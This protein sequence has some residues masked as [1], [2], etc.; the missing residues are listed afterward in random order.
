VGTGYI[1][2]LTLVIAVPLGVGASI[3]LAE[4][5]RDDW[6]TRVV[7]FGVEALAGIPSIVF[8]LFGFALFV[9][10]LG[11]NFSILSG[12]LTLACLCLPVIIRTCE[13][14]IKAV[15]VKL[16]EASLSLGATKWQTITKVVLPA[17]LPGIITA[18]I[19]TVGRVVEETACLYVTMGGSSNMPTSIWSNARTLS[20][21][22]YYL[23]MET[24]AINKALATGVVLVLIIV[25]INFVTRWLT[26]RYV[27]RSFGG[28]R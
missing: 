8:G 15:P 3:Y 12:S 27:A 28:S 13:E 21:H 16:R 23:A 10:A 1:V 7:R 18:I 14:A 4:Y 9:I 2:A 17:A 19:L 24:R 6:F 5:A 25:V 20:L 26:T 22:L 11:L